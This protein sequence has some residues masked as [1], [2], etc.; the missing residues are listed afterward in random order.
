MPKKTIPSYCLH[1]HSGQAIVTL[2]GKTFYLGKHKSKESRE[3]YDDLIAEYM[4][5]KRK[6]PPTRTQHGLLIEQLAVGYLQYA[7]KYYTGTRKKPT[8][9][10]HLCRQALDPVIRYY[11]KHPVTDFVPLSLVFIR[12]KWVEAGVARK[13]I[14]ERTGFIKQMFQ[15]GATYGYI[16]ASIYNA[17]QAVPNLKL[18]RTSAPEYD[19]VP[20]IDPEVVEK[21]I[22]FMPPVIADMVRVQLFAGMRPQDVRNMRSCDFDRT[23][24]IWKYTPFTHTKT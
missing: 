20:P 12:D 3:R 9:S 4:E 13:N 24:D 15:W 21:T 10:F 18:G 5:N 17:L 16:E 23:G 1:K 2:N 11:G 14:N 8:K 22:P 19:E 7:E 6:L